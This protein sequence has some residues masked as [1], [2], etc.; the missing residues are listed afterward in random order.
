MLISNLRW[1]YVIKLTIVGY[2][3]SWVITTWHLNDVSSLARRHAT[4]R[5]S[6]CA[7]LVP[8]GGAEFI[9]DTLHCGFIF[10]LKNQSKCRFV[11]KSESSQSSQ[12]LGASCCTYSFYQTTLETIPTHIIGQ[13]LDTA[14][15]W[16][17]HG[18]Q[19]S[20]KG[21]S[22]THRPSKPGAD[23]NKLKQKNLANE[24]KNP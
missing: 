16:G 9:Q 13:Q 17:A 11:A 8:A 12:N 24:C 6:L 22:N 23:S 2:Y 4:P 19:K 20:S 15:L 7:L 1:N 3:W 21:H 18:P 5:L 10:H 14:G